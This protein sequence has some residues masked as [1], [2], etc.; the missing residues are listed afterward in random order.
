M[1]IDEMAYNSKLEESPLQ[2]LLCRLE[3][4]QSVN[5]IIYSVQMSWSLWLLKIVEKKK[6]KKNEQH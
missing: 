3:L 2:K 6:G 1:I 4:R 5:K